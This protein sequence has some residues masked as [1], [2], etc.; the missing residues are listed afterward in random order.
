[1]QETGKPLHNMNMPAARLR[2]FFSCIKDL[3]IRCRDAAN[4]QAADAADQKIERAAVSE[5]PG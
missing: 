4:K 1:M 2:Y 3:V 5:Q